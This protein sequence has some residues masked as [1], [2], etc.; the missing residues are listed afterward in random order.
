GAVNVAAGWLTQWTLPGNQPA[1]YYVGL[2]GSYEALPLIF[3]LGGL[4]VYLGRGDRGAL[5]LAWW[6]A[7]AL[8]FY[9][10]SPN[11]TPEA[12]LVILLPL[13]WT[14]GRA[15]GDLLQSLLLDFSLQN[16]GVFVLLGILT[17]GIFGIN[18]SSYASDGQPNHLVV[19]AIASGMLVL[20]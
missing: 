16:D 10:L 20:L 15:I 9:T 11:K 5:F 4:F 2:L 19:V 3:G 1:S 17:C 13:I 6:V 18:L 14:A 12:M 8:T 7:L